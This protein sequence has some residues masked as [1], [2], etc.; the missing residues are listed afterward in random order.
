[1]SAACRVWDV[2]LLDLWVGSYVSGCSQFDC[3]SLVVILV[4]VLSSL[5]VW[6]WAIEWAV[7]FLS[8][9]GSSV[10]VG[11]IN[12]LWVDLDVGN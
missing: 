3:L 2:L 4:M 10:P 8:S 7:G 6:Y 5:D 11:G 12:V 1:M 9:A